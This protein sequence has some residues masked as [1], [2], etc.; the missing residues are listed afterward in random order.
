MWPQTR[1]DG[2]PQCHCHLGCQCLFRNSHMWKYLTLPSMEDIS[3]NS[4]SEF[5]FSQ[6]D[7]DDQACTLITYFRSVFYIPLQGCDLE[8]CEL[9]W[10]G[11]S[12]NG[13]HFVDLFSWD[14]LSVSKSKGG[15]DFHNLFWWCP[16]FKPQTLHILCIIHVN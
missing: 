6:T 13:N 14:K 5:S 2:L 10:L 8:T 16:G 11:S 12:K 15:K 3:K 9:F 7:N 4:W 1:Y